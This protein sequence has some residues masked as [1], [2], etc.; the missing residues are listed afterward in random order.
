MASLRNLAIGALRLAGITQHRRRAATQQP[1]PHPAPHRSRHPIAHESGITTLCRGLGPGSTRAWPAADH[2]RLHGTGRPGAGDPARGGDRD[3]APIRRSRY[4]IPRPGIS[5]WPVRDDRPRREGNGPRRGGAGSAVRRRADRA[6]HG[7][8]DPLR[9]PLGMRAGQRRPAR[10][11]VDARRRRAHAAEQRRRGLLPRPPRRH[12]DGC[13]TLAGG[14]GRAARGGAA[15]RPRGCRNGA[16]PRSSASR[17]CAS[18]RARR[19]GRPA[20]P[21][22]RQA[23]H[24]AGAAAAPA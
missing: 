11:P 18:D 21:E 22:Q 9:A 13:R 20:A 4:R 15:L 24:L 1:R 5:R 3:R 2:Q 23:D 14:G 10:R 12:P 6:G 8:R 16:M 19:G 17:T 7:G